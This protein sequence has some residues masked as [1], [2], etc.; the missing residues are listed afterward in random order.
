MIANIE[1]ET[2]KQQD[3]LKQQIMGEAEKKF[4][5]KLTVQQEASNKVLA[6]LKS[7]IDALTKASEEQK[8]TVIEQFKNKLSEQAQQLQNVEGELSQRQSNIP[9]GPNPYRAPPQNS[10]PDGETLDPEEQKKAL[11]NMYN[12]VSGK[13]F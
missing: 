12:A 9:T 11:M 5:E 8:R 4:N 3:L 1:A 2:Q 13:K 7:Q 10:N 6:D